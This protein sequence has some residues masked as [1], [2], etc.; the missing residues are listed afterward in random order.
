[1]KVFIETNNYKHVILYESNATKIV[2]VQ[3]KNDRMLDRI[4]ITKLGTKYIAPQSITIYRY[5]DEETIN[6]M[7]S[8]YGYKE[9]E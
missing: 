5:E 9:G 8:L 4:S 2:F 1:M 3:D 6:S 7:L